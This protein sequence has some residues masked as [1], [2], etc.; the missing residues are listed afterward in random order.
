MDKVDLSKPKWDQN[1]YLGRAKHFL[2]GK[3]FF[4][5]E[6][7]LLLIKRKRL[8]KLF[9]KRVYFQQKCIISLLFYKEKHKMYNYL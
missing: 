3:N 8:K 2:F 5:V 1:T 6:R 4:F 7:A 9:L